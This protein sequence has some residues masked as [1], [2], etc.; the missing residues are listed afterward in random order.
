MDHSNIPVFKRPT[1][2]PTREEL[3]SI[4]NPKQPKISPN[5]TPRILEHATKQLHQHQ[6]HRTPAAPAPAAASTTQSVLGD[7]PL[8]ESILNS[9]PS[10]IVPII[11]EPNIVSDFFTDLT[12]DLSDPRLSYQINGIL[13]KFP[14]PI[15]P[16]VP[17]ATVSAPSIRRS[18]NRDDEDSDY[19]DEDDYDDEDDDKGIM[20][21]FIYPPPPVVNFDNLPFSLAS[22]RKKY[23]SL[24]NG[25]SSTATTTTTTTPNPSK[26]GRKPKNAESR[27]VS[28]FM[29]S[30]ND[31][32]HNKV[33]VQ[34]LPLPFPPPN[35]MKYPLNSD[36]A[37]L[38]PHNVFS[39]LLEANE[40]LPRI[41]MVVASAAGSLFEMR[42]QADKEGFTIQDF[43]M[44]RLTKKKRGKGGESTEVS[45]NE[46]PVSDGETTKGGDTED[47]MAREDTEGVLR[48][49][50]DEDEEEDDDEV[51]EVDDDDEEEEGAEETKDDDEA[52][53]L[54]IDTNDYD[55]YYAVK[56]G[57]KNVFEI[58][59]TDPK[60]SKV[61]G[62]LSNIKNKPLEQ[63]DK[64]EDE[65]E[66]VYSYPSEA[67]SN[68][69]RVNQDEFFPTTPREFAYASGTNRER[70]RLGLKKSVEGI[71][72]FEKRHRLD[73]F[74]IKKYQLLKKIDDLKNSKIEFNKNVIYDQDLKN[75][76]DDLEYKRDVELI[77]LKVLENYELL[78]NSLNFYNNSNKIYKIINMV[79]INK[80][81]KLKNFFEFQKKMFQDYIKNKKDIFDVNSRDANKLILGLS[82][83]D[84]SFEIKEIFK[85]LI[86][87]DMAVSGQ[88]PD[89]S[90]MTVPDLKFSEVDQNKPVL[91]HDFMPL[92]T[93]EEFNIITGD[94]SHKSLTNNNHKNSKNA[95]ATNNKRIIQSSIYEKMLT[96]GSD[97]NLSDS[98]TATGTNTTP[99]P[100]S[101][102]LPKRRGGGRRSANTPSGSTAATSPDKNG[103]S[104][105][106]TPRPSE[107]FK[108]F[109]TV[110][111]EAS[112]L[113]KIM[114]QFNGPQMAKPDELVNDLEQMGIQTKWPVTK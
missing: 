35:Y 96:S 104:S 15:P 81:E 58:N 62:R 66:D 61:K 94:L 92:I 100:S 45:E 80:L 21:P 60:F 32:S 82:N 25:V 1:K 53:F 3:A 19:A 20:V 97:T 102:G 46:A 91:I 73:I 47:E 43:E 5:S 2:L 37:N 30:P 63:P 48:A 85:N 42:Q 113:A 41:D 72:D 36:K 88:T 103:Y 114:K 51:A 9:V 71:E 87:E 67:I 23:E 12:T 29:R 31:D 13:R 17:P 18:Y 64:R 95:A 14:P 90:P 78:K 105:S 98:G 77:E 59:M 76:N 108:E 6:P 112:I 16:P 22:F 33:Y 101:G 24:H 93:P 65:V 8:D 75:I 70:R 86:V 79:L 56:E 55:D 106:G 110:Y 49:N 38:V 4:F 10:N 39:E 83:K 107:L 28:P 74:H 84:Y 111:S 11:H 26:R 54:K 68:L 34:A 99:G 27:G 69:Y 52:Y 7:Y 89:L 57:P 44:D 109:D 40:E 50:V